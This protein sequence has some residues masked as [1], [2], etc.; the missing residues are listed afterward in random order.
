MN[1]NDGTRFCVNCVHYSCATHMHLCKHPD[2]LKVEK[3][4]VTGAPRH[5]YCDI[6]RETGTECGPEGKRYD[7]KEPF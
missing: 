7:P 1:P 6:E 2:L 5:V 3:N 4:P